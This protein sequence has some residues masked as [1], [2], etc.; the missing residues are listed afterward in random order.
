MSSKKE[1]IL[2]TG[3][4]GQQGGA[5]TRH[6]LAKGWPVRA[7]TRD[8][9]SPAAQALA[10]AGCQVVQGDLDDRASLD[11]ALNGVYG[12]YSMQTPFMGVDVEERQGKAMADAADA[13]GVQHF[14]YASVGGA[15]RNTGIPHFESK[16]QIERHVRSLGLSATVL[17]PVYF[18]DNLNWQRS[19]ILSGTLTSMGMDPDKPLHLIAA[20]D[21]G[22]FAVL[23]F[24]NPQEYLGQAIELAGDSLTEP[25]FADVFAKV[26]GR[27]VDLVQP[28]E[29]P[30]YPDMV[31]MVN[32]FNEKGYEA[33]IPALRVRHPG[34]MTFETWLRKNGWGNAI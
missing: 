27:P 20:D 23:A 2:V 12:I 13:A 29:P 17:R 25:Q 34:L 21:I 6:L 1:M 16:W 7:L 32:W 14:V 19:Q 10:E 33:D 5:A 30:A 4:T 15:E 26:I 22:A 31:T 24:E 8:P 3:A 28:E 18:M 9:N 11:H